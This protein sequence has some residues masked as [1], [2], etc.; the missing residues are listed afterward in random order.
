MSFSR[1]LKTQKYRD[2][3][4]GDLAVDFISTGF[5][6]IKESFQR[7][8]PCEGAVE[9]YNQ[10][11]REYREAKASKSPDQYARCA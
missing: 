5:S 8:I 11:K 2:D 9:A 1:W 6:T 3:I 10:A 7:Y 4:V